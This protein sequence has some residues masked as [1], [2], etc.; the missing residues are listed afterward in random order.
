MEQIGPWVAATVAALAAIALLV[1]VLSVRRRRN[2]EIRARDRTERLLRLQGAAMDSAANSIFITDRQ[3]RIE[4]SNAAF[5]RLTGWRGK[6]ALDQNARHLLLPPGSGMPGDVVRSLRD[7]LAAGQP[8]R[9]EM[10][11]VRRDGDLFVVDQTVTPVAQDKAGPVS[12]FVVVQED[13]TERRRAD[14]RIRFLSSYDSLTMLPNRLLFREQLNRYIERAR[15]DKTG[16][17]VLFLDLLRFTHYN[18]VLGHD[19]GDRLLVRVVDRLLRAARPAETVARVGGDEFAMVLTDGTA[20]SAARLAGEVLA[21]VTRPIDLDGHSVRVGASIG[22]TL[23]PGDGSDAATLMKNADT[24]MYR[25]MRE[26]PG[27]YRFFSPA[28]DAE[29][30]ARRRIEVELGRAVAEGGLELYYQPIVAIASRRIIALEALVRWRRGDG[31]VIGPD[32]FIALAEENGMIVG[33]GEWV[34]GEACRQSREWSK[35]GVPVVPLAVN[36]SAVQMRRRN[37]PKLIRRVLEETGLAPDQLVIELTES[38]VVDDPEGAESILAE[39]KAL[40]VGLA[41]DD[42]GIGYSSLARLKQFPMDKLK[43]DRSFVIDLIASP[44]D[45]AIARAVVALGHGLGLEVVSEGVETEAQLRYLEREGVDAVQGFLFSPPVP[46]AA[47]GELLRRGVF[48]N[49][50]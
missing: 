22:I 41:M 19:A 2:G 33:I 43:L 39:I 7:C 44:E 15:S 24:A 16:L 12:H 26:C 30:A 6:E 25:A 5:E 13:I 46:A 47:A 35:A 14:E 17:A 32:H 28:M 3:G 36:V 20:R 48:P 38:A 9:G 34:L 45:A 8:W 1:H 29:L 37:L 27:G 23:Y 40:G 49:D 18:D 50:A 11:L 21:A 31:R 42:F 4:W 10:E